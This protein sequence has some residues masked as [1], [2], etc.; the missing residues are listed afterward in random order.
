MTVNVGSI[1]DAYRSTL[2]NAED[3]VAGVDKVSGSGVFGN[4]LE[5][6]MDGTVDSLKNAEAVGIAAVKGK[7]TVND[8]VTAVSAAETALQTVVTIRDR[9]IAAYQELMRSGV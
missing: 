3:G 2:K 6:V 9:I 5:K 4:I 8:V 1:L 7:A